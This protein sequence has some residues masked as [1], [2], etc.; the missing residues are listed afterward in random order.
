MASSIGI[1]CADP[2][3]FEAS[4]L[5]YWASCCAD[6]EYIFKVG[7][8]PFLSVDELLA[9]M[10]EKYGD[11]HD[12]TKWEQVPGSE[13]L[14]QKLATKQSDP[15][16]KN[17]LIGAF[18]RA[19]DI[20]S[21]MEKYLPDVYEETATPG[22]YTYRGGS[23][24]GGAVIYGDGKFLY[25]HHASDPWCGKLV[26]SF[27]LVRLH[28]FGKLDDEADVKTPTNRLPSYYAMSEL[29]TKD[30]KVTQELAKVDFA[31]VEESSDWKSRLELN[32]R[33]GTIKSTMDNI[34]LILENDPNLKAK[35]AMNE[36]SGRAEVLEDLPW[37]PFTERRPWS[38]NDSAGLYW[39]FEKFYRITGNAKID[40][41]L[42]LHSEKHRF[43]EVKNY[44]MSLTWDKV[45][46]LDTL[47][48]D[49]L[50]AKDCS[51]VRIVTRKAFTAAVARA[52][53]PGCKY[54]TM[55]I[56]S[57]RQG[58]GKSSFL[59]K[60]SKGW[61]NDSIRTF[62]G[63]EAS[64]LLQ[65]VWIV[66]IGELDA[67][68]RTDVARIKQ[69]L[70]QRFDRFREAYGR[71]AKEFPRR[72]VFFGTTNAKE[73]LSD[74]TGNRRFWVVDIGDY[75]LKK[76]IWKDLNNEID[77]I[78]AEAVMRWRLGEN[79]HL[80]SAEEKDAIAE[81]EKHRETSGREGLIA[82]FLNKPIPKDWSNWSLDNRRIFW[83]S[84]NPNIPNLV[85]RDKVCALEIWCEA[86][87]GQAK[88]FKR[89][90]AQEINDIMRTIPGWSKSSNGLRFGYCGYQRDFLKHS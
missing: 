31:Q 35:F 69:F 78:W 13:N 28:K 49:Y 62:E 24:T 67:F 23:T 76:N 18:C 1:E 70:S 84:P 73:F 66:E 58:L 16:A 82:E 55:L 7:D 74:R 37:I 20:Y 65:G 90:D 87:G 50:G 29:A 27:D 53:E 60:M 21:A 81:Q 8:K 47:L 72:C 36:F 85:Q 32:G 10:N 11:W 86:L 39:Y 75:A 26:N 56:L 12:A 59:D 46:R 5:M 77:Q 2:I 22:R 34:W 48:I 44:L 41:A 57:G 54:D 51:Y 33:T 30:K 9:T 64:E 89:A 19:Y 17:N 42:S 45:P 40:G 63:K 6:S 61:F 80:I 52:M 14:Y 79:L 25:S 3:T 15:L 43:N 83:N 4:R 38:D 88:D 68:R 71:H